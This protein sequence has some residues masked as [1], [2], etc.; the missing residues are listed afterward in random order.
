MIVLRELHCK[1]SAFLLTL[2]F[3]LH[4]ICIFVA[5]LVE[6]PRKDMIRRLGLG[7]YILWVI[8]WLLLPLPLEAVENVPRK[9]LVVTSY[10]PDTQAM[11]S[12]LGAFV[13]EYTYMGGKCH[14]VV[15]TI[16]CKNLS[17]LYAWKD[18]LLDVL[19]KHVQGDRP[20][21][22][23]LMG[24]EAWA[25]YLSL[26]EEWVRDIPSIGA[27]ISENAVAIPSEKVELDKWN[28]VST[29][30]FE[31]YKTHNI[32]GGIVYVYDIEKNVDLIMDCFP[33]TQRIA[34]ISDNTYGGIAMQALVRKVMKKYPKLDLLLLDG[35]KDSFMDVSE[36]IRQL[37][38]N[39]CIL[40]GTWRVDYTENYIVGNTTY[41]LHDANTDVPAFSLTTI[42]LG[43]WV[44]GGYTPYYH[45]LG[46]EMADMVFRYLDHGDRDAAKVI[47]VSGGYRFDMEKLK[48]FGLQD[49]EIPENAE[50]VNEPLNFFEQ[51]QKLVIV[52]LV[53][54]FTLLAG[55]F[56]I[57]YYA[58]RV[59]R[60]RNNLMASQ[61]QLVEAK[62][63][64]E[65][66][67]R[68][69]SAFLA[70]MSHE[71]RT[72]LN[73]IV[74][75]SQVLTSGE[76]PPEE[77]KEFC[78]IIKKNSDSLLALVSDILDISRM[79]SGH[80]KMTL[81]KAD[82]VEIIQHSILTVKQSRRTEAEFRIETEMENCVVMTDAYRLKQVLVNLLSNAAKF[83]PS[84][85]ITLSLEADKDRQQLRFAVTDTGCGIPPEKAEKVF[86]RF[87]KLDEFAQGTGLGLS[88][89]RLIVEKLGGKIWVDTNY[90]V[91]ARFVFTH[92]MQM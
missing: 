77:Q 86:E 37:P 47:K 19:K 72:P 66:A 78:D 17:G 85:S 52:S 15:E 48:E 79:E 80:I 31:D 74:G 34:F 24:Q 7:R 76:F 55:L 71:I 49:R 36:K 54:L 23:I 29:N 59:R 60:L 83:T 25:S 18:R 1:N 38:D 58:I 50:L 8:V 42:G 10:N 40:M 21:L 14:I 26:D 81:E 2:W 89:S 84:G 12:H 67:N 88:I 30:S 92:P 70:N 9:V 87:E 62:D 64:A 57:G 45:N 16:N 61:E 69:K 33:K 22:L 27:L 11:A 82:V 75:F 32:I 39:T 46:Y 73:A 43:H 53:V 4:K 44:V 41:M 90:K 63:K 3:V 5:I 68:L 28:P 51:H 56:G 91:G 65:E 13:D 6:N 35:R 20:S